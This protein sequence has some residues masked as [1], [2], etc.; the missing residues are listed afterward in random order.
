M[1]WFIRPGRTPPAP[2]ESGRSANRLMKSL[3][4]RCLAFVA[5]A[6]TFGCLA[7][8]PGAAAASFEEARS[9]F[10]EGRFEEAARIAET[11]DTSSGQALA[12]RALAIH[13]YYILEED[14]DTREPL[15][16]RSIGLAKRA[17]EIDPDNADAHIMLA[18]TLGRHAQV[19][20][21]LEASNRG[22]AEKIREAAETALGID[23][24]LVTALLT[25]GRWHS[26][27]IGVMGSFLAR[28][29]YGAREEEA[30]AFLER[31]F[32][33]APES[34]DVALEYALGLLMLD[35]DEY[36]D[37][38]HDLLILAVGIPSGDAYEAIIHA[39]AA[40]HLEGLE[41]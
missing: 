22:Y 15:L 25:L 4:I 6:V 8:A 2:A 30:L 16:L 39:E 34:K 17:V 14:D 36:R 33:L 31:A 20:S 18:A 11:L 35:D 1:L 26:E 38:A 37:K 41:D 10:T 13:A 12:A 28:T 5:F 3:P 7:M 27:L 29:L 40:R 21:S 9:A 24:D 23:P 19:I 32:E